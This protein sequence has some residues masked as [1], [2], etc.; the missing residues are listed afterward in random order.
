MSEVPLS[1]CIPAYGAARYIGA[2]LESVLAQIPAGAEVIVA[3]DA[4]TDATAEIAERFGAPVRVLRLPHGG[5]G[6]AFNAAVA[7]SSGRLLAAVDADDLW[8]A[9]KIDAQLAAL[10][11]DPSLDA[12]FGQV[13]EFRTPELPVEATA[14][15]QCRSEPHRGL[16]RG[17]MM[18]RRSAW[19][20]VGPLPIDLAVG[21]F[22]AWYAA[23]ID[24]GLKVRMLDQ[25]VLARRIHGDNT[26]LRVADGA[27]G[28]LRVVKAAL[29]RR[30]AMRD[31]RLESAAISTIPGETFR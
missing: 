7:A 14:R 13:V 2:A 19:D 8:V 11:E 6:A 26:M 1:V 27:G 16:L 5:P 24:S 29:D 18:L 9:G 30:R 21:E 28:Y 31:G 17:T 25:V 4:S 15:W 3:D 10:G 23:A 20:R 22:I 12:V